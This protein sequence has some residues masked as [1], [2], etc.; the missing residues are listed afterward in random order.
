MPTSQV[1]VYK[2]HLKFLVSY[3]L[4]LHIHNH[5]P[6]LLYITSNSEIFSISNTQ[7]GMFYM[8]TDNTDL[9]LIFIFVL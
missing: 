9:L 1:K 3:Y 4:R 2:D 8:H 5:F 6:L 7:H